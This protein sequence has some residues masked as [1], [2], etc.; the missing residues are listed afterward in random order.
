MPDVSF[1][2]SLCSSTE[3]AFKSP[4]TDDEKQQVQEMVKDTE[5]ALDKALECFE[6]WEMRVKDYESTKQDR[7]EWKQKCLLALAK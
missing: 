2:L 4:K 1:N 6:E 3:K 5:N 7:T